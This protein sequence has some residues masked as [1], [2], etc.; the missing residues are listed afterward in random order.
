MM[1]YATRG[2]YRLLIALFY[3]KSEKKAMAFSFNQDH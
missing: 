3:S 2:L 1:T